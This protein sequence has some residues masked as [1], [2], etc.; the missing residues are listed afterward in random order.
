MNLFNKYKFN[1]FLAD[2]SYLFS[3]RVISML[4]TFV[5]SIILARTLGPSSKGIVTTILVLP[6]IIFTLADLGLR[7]VITF[8]IGKKI[9]N[10]QEVISTVFFLFIVTSIIGCVA[11]FISFYIQGFFNIYQATTLYISIGLLPILLISS[12]GTGILLAKEKIKELSI[13]NFLQIISYSFGVLL[14]FFIA[15]ENRIFIAI[16]VN[17][18]SNTI[19]AI[20]ILWHCNSVGK[21]KITYFAGLPWL[22]IKKGFMFAIALFVLYLNYRVDVLILGQTASL[23]EVGI[24]SIGVNIAELLWIIPNT[25]NT[26]NF[27]R[28]ANATDS[29]SYAQKTARVLRVSL[30][31]NLIPLIGLFFIS[32]WLI[33][34]LYGVDYLK[35]GAVVQAILLGVWMNTIYKVINSDLAGRGIPQVAIWVYCLSLMIN[36]ILNFIW[37]PIYGSLGAAW[38]TSVSYTFGALLYAYVYSKLSNIRFFT[39]LLPKYNDFKDLISKVS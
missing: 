22:F 39:L 4:L 10:D 12:Y 32:P 30:W 20:Y 5:V 17:L 9:Y 33:P 25:I 28:S 1:R 37:D 14:L 15:E 26:V 23:S 21:I 8:Y 27:S 24:Y 29:L 31:V 19:S 38:A 35:S 7:Q 3:S 2:F 18:F 34:L 13:S 36:I 11:I 16:L 6:T